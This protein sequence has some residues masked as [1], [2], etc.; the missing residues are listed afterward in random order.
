[1]IFSKTDGEK[2]LIIILKVAMID[3]DDSS[4][5]F[6]EFLIYQRKKFTPDLNEPLYLMNIDISATVE[7]QPNINENSDDLSDCEREIVL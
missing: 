1:M 7:K 4:S 6:D 2:V 3:C 5:K